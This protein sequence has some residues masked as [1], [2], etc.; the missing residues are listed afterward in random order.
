MAYGVKYS[1]STYSEGLGKCMVDILKEGYAGETF[2]FIIVAQGLTIQ[3]NSTEYFEVIKSNSIEIRII[4]N[5]EDFYEFDD[6]LSAGEM[7]YLVKVYNDNITLF[8]GFVVC[9]ASEQSWLRNGVFSLIATCNLTRLEQYSPLILQQHGTYLLIDIIEEC[10][11]YTGMSL[12]IMVNCSLKESSVLTVGSFLNTTWI[13]SDLF[14]DDNVTI[15]DCKKVIEQILRSFSCVLYYY[16]DCWW[17]ERVK[18]M[19]TSP[20]SYFKYDVD[21]SN[22][23]I[24][25]DLDSAYK[26]SIGKELILIRTSQSIRYTPGLKEIDI[27]LKEK[28]R[29]NYLDYYFNG[30]TISNPLLTIEYISPLFGQWEVLNEGW[31][32]YSYGSALLGMN[33]WVQILDQYGVGGDALQALNTIDYTNTGGGFNSILFRNSLNGIYSRIRMSKNPGASSDSTVTLNINL[34]FKLPEN[35]L[36]QYDTHFVQDSKLHPTDHKFFVRFFIGQILD[37]PYWLVF[38]NT[39]LK[40]EWVQQNSITDTGITGHP[41]I[42]ECMVNF[43]DFKDKKTYYHEFS[44]SIQIIDSDT[45]KL[46]TIGFIELGWNYPQYNRT[47]RFN[48]ANFSLRTSIYGDIVLTTNEA[49]EDNLIIGKLN[50]KFVSKQTVDLYL[51][52]N[53]HDNVINAMFKDNQDRTHTEQWTDAIH[54]AIDKPITECVIEDMFQIYNKTRREINSEIKSLGFPILIESQTPQPFIALDQTNRNWIG[55]SIAPNGDVY[56]CVQHGDIY[57]QSGGTGVFTALGVGDKNWFDIT[58]APNGDV[59]ACVFGG[60]IWKRIGGIGSFTALGQIVRDWSCIT[61]A[62]NGYIYAG[63]SN[64]YIYRQTTPISGIND[65]LEYY[66]VIKNW[67]GLTGAPNGSVYACVLGEDIYKDSGSNFV[68]L[69]QTHRNYVRI[70]SDKYNNIY[71][72]LSTGFYIQNSGIGN[73]VLYD[74][75]A[76]FWSG[77]AVNDRDVIYAAVLGGDIWTKV[78]RETNYNLLKPFSLVNSTMQGRIFYINGYQLTLDS[79]EYQINLKEYVGEDN[80]D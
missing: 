12:P 37:G 6:L 46:Y 48:S 25:V 42:I 71:V 63:V 61:A 52:D 73:F 38:N 64:G 56:A 33:N 51:F 43:N 57:I 70:T 1:T 44:T 31:V 13:D 59:Y 10:L 32:H 22:F 50:N 9:D 47:T 54:P 16:N 80:I 55:I 15:R 27:N 76:K 8:S 68:P 18:D 74:S 21:S 41:A 3:Y 62:I 29:F 78:T 58:V 24:W 28:H 49:S 30:I 7:E 75:T 45:E 69:S 79:S 17:I 67:N 11:L 23:R 35:F 36:Q 14:Y 60:D 39:Y 26:A 65:F 40:Y 34:K 2:S 5:K 77:L 53:E 72:S 20:R 4:N 66:S 19:E